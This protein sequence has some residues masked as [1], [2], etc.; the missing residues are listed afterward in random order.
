MIG[1]R[2]RV[3]LP[4]VF[5]KIRQDSCGQRERPVPGG[6]YD[7]ELWWCR[8]HGSNRERS[9]S[10]FFFL[11]FCAAFFFLLGNCPLVATE[12]TYRLR[13]SILCISPLSL[14]GYECHYVT[15]LKMIIGT[16]RVK[17]D[18]SIHE[19]CRLEAEQTFGPSRQRRCMLSNKWKM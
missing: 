9:E 6:G 10:H 16:I 18:V 5:I 15:L 12:S 14:R 13:V 11:L 1:S 7:R 2:P 4:S 17:S 19:L 3:H 8:Q